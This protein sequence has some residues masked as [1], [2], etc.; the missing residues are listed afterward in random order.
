[1]ITFDVFTRGDKVRFVVEQNE[2]YFRNTLG[3]CI[4][5]QGSLTSAIN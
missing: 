3:R 2:T 1:M 5:T 4:Y